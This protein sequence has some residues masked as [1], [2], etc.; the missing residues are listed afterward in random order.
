MATTEQPPARK[1][2]SRISASQIDTY[3]TCA[4]KWAWKYIGRVDGP[5]HPSAALGERVHGVLEGWLRDGKAIDTSTREGKIA[6]A[7]VSKLPMPGRGLVERKFDWRSPA[8]I[9]YTGRLDLEHERDDVLV[10][11]DHKT[12]SSFGW[13]KTEEDLKTETPLNLG[14]RGGADAALV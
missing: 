9:L 11:H 4:R 3:R 12:T 8:G 13:A 2:E 7:G 14:R 5:Q 6:A 1:G 10:V